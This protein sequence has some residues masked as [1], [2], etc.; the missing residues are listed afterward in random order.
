MA[1]AAHG[2]VV[3]L[4][5]EDGHLYLCVK[6]G[7]GPPLTYYTGR[8]SNLLAVGVRQ[9]LADGFD[10]TFEADVFIM[11][12]SGGLGGRRENRLGQFLGLDL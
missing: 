9:V 6:Q 5:D 8:L 10:D 11:A 4:D 12:A 2:V 7:G 3:V 1:G